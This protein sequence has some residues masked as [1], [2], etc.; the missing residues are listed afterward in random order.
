MLK[1]ELIRARLVM[2]GNQVSTRPL[3]ADYHYLTVAGE[4]AAL[5]QTHVGHTDGELYDAVRDYEGDSL[6][7]PVRRGLAS[8]LEARC[9]FGSAPPVKPI[10]LRAALMRRGPVMTRRDLFTPATREQALRETAGQ[11]GL[12]IEQVEN[13]LCADLAEG[14]V[15]QDVGEPIAPADLIARY[16]LNWRA[17]CCTGRARCG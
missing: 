2:Q 9:T 11:F 4:L 16:N 17:A 3:P 13:A 15:L 6:D 1:A 12:R 7:Y 8:V 5:F 10:D 14:Q